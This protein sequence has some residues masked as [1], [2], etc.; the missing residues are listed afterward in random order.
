M[1]LFV[2][3]ATGGTGRAIV[4]QALTRGHRVTAFAR[5]PEQLEEREGLRLERGDPRRAADLAAVLPGHGVVISALGR[6]TK[7]DG[8]ILGDGARAMTEAM[9]IARMTRLIVVSSALL[10]P[11]IG[12]VGAFLRRYVFA[13]AL[14]DSLEM[15]NIVS[16][17]DIEWAIVRP[18][19]LTNGAHRQR[20]RV[21]TN[22]LP[23]GGRSVSRSDLAHYLLD[24]AEGRDHPRTVVG[25][26][27]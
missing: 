13:N 6:R 5:S 1:S 20:Y 22:G 10:F 8:S 15:E 16:A 11:D 18:P 17:S 26:S 19:R 25:V 2:V 7:A 3:G 4:D 27:Y 24:E 21:Q 12:L 14:R 23:A 9:K